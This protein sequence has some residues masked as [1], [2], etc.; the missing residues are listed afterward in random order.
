MHPPPGVYGLGLKGQE[1]RVWGAIDPGQPLSHQ[2]L[3]EAATVDP[4]IGQEAP[5]A[6]SLA[7]VRHQS[8]GL[9]GDVVPG[10]VCG[11]LSQ[12]LPRLGGVD[13]QETDPVPIAETQGV[14]VEHRG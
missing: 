2:G 12:G 13:A 8:N 14:A 11:R 7:A 6:I 4:D 10:E 5:V 3:G 1:R 9:T